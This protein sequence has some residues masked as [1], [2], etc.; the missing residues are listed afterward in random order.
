MPTYPYIS[1][2]G[3]VAKAFE[4]LRKGFPAKVD[5]AYL[6]RFQIAPSN[7]SYLIAILRFLGLIDDEGNRQDGKVDFFYGNEEKF[8]SGLDAALRE[9]YKQ[10][11]DEMGDGVYAR[12]R[13]ELG[14]WFR[15][16]D[17]TSDLIGKRQA[18]TFLALA[19]LAAK[20]EA[21]P[22]KASAPSA[23]PRSRR[24]PK[25]PEVL[26]ASKKPDV[27][28]AAAESSRERVETPAGARAADVGLTVRI[29]VNLPA[30]GDAET[31]D[32]IFASIKRH[33]IA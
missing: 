15:G 33:L 24:A 9:S 30:G 6:Q 27:A 8:Q 2:S 26:S 11:F 32:A 31:Y 4:Q 5:A 1:G 28:E 13:D 10:L 16:A 12:P 14:H 3:P 7:E 19:G 17:K 25:V 20:V 21:S 23:K 18:G 22:A 29:E